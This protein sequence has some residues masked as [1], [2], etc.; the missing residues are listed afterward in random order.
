MIAVLRHNWGGKAE[1]LGIFCQ[2]KNNI[3][4]RRICWPFFPT[5]SSKD[6]GQKVRGN[7]CS[8]QSQIQ[9]S[10]VLIG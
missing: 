8:A 5:N 9:K 1:E 10:C 4:G 3:D 6:I 2:D 7:Y